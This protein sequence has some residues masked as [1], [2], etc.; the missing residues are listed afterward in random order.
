MNIDFVRRFL[1]RCAVVNYVVLLVWFLAF[2]LAHDAMQSL[3]GRWFH[4]SHEQFDAL[5]YGGM[6]IYKLGIM[7][8][9]LVPWLVLRVMPGPAPK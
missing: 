6:A 3:H 2:V 1:L 8:F 9:N 5:H 4:L 7:L